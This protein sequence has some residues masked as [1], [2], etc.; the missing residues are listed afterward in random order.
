MLQHKPATEYA[1]D[2]VMLEAVPSTDTERLSP[3]SAKMFYRLEK[4]LLVESLVIP[5][6]RTGPVGLHPHH[7]V[8]VIR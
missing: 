7:K 8:F 5:V 4:F 6:L 3:P 2:F 1:R